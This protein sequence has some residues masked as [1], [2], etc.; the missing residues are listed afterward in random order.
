[1]ADKYKIDS[2]KLMYHPNRVSA[3]LNKK[4]VYPIYVEISPCGACNHRCSFCS[5]DFMGYKKQLLDPDMLKD[6]LMEMA[7]L[8][9]KSVMFAGEGEPFLHKSLPGIII[10]AK[11]AG[12]DVAITTNGVLMRPKVTDKIISSVEWIK[13]SL[14][15]GT[16]GTYANIHGTAEK[17][18]NAVLSNL[19]YAVKERERQK[20]NCVLGLQILLIPENQD[21]VVSLARTAKNIGADYLVV[22]PYTHHSRNDHDFEIDYSLYND[23]ET[24]LSN[25]NTDE[26]SAIFRARAM[27][28]WDR[29]NRDY[30][31]CLALPFW[32]YIDAGGNVWGC[33]AHLLDDRFNY[34]SLYEQSFKDIWE[35]EKRKASLKWVDSSL[36][37]ET[38]KMNCRMDEV[39]RYL[40]QLIDLPD[41]VN[42][43]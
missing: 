31:K 39:N 43:I 30:S 8:G 11:K 23:L 5:V 33:S 35:G 40:S 29:K 28:K 17:D 6:R 26:F 2:H 32:S 12:I 14:N 41:H 42:F 37:I 13:V 19:E 22:K 38:C 1:M 4:N 15:A 7:G 21:E 3:W 24:E 27:K 25:Y 36:D 34:G 10:E 18:F 9:I 20:S 16:P